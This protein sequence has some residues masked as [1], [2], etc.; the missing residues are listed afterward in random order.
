MSEP[1]QWH[2]NT[3]GEAVVK[4]LQK[5]D[6]AATYAPTSKEAV[7]KLLELIPQEASIGYGGSMTL[8]ALGIVAKLTE[9]GNPVLSPKKG[10]DIVAVRRKHLSADVYLSGT[11]AVTLDGKLYNVD[12]TGNRVAAMTFGPEKVFIVVG[13]NKVVK[14]LAEA[15]SRVKIWAAP[16][17]CK[18]LGLANPCTQT[19]VCVDCQSPAR[20]C[21]VTL[22]MNKRPKKTDVHVIVIGEE[23]GL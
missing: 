20:I 10:D 23:L 21:N 14:D 9:R 16:P 12:G 1:I 4:A 5:N 2:R 15:E 7:D 3:I 6:F 19:R 8:D 11:N 13:I 18:R 22:I 17:N